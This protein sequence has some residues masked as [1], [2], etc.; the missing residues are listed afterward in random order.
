MNIKEIIADLRHRG[1]SLV[2]V[3]PSNYTTP[4]DAEDRGIVTNAIFVRDDGWTLGVPTDLIA[5]A[6]AMFY[7]RWRFIVSAP[8]YKSKRFYRS[9]K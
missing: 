5:N 8:D 2:L 4:R 3:G 1:P 6:K 9:K 7:D